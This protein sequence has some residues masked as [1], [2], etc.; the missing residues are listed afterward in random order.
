MHSIFETKHLII[1]ALCAIFITA[2]TLATRKWSQEKLCKA[3]FYIG[4]VAEF[5]KVFNYIL[6]N[7]AELGGI[8]PKTDLPFHLCSMQMPMVAI[9][10]L[11][12]SEKLK[13]MI[14]SFMMPGCLVGA[15]AALLLATDSSLNGSV[16]ITLEYFGYHSVLVIFGL[17]LLM[18]KLEM[19]VRSYVNCLKCLL[20][21]FFFSIY[22]N[23][24]LYDGVSDINFMYV[25]SPP[26][27]GLPYLTEEHGW[28]VYIVHY[29]ALVLFGVT[30][31]YCKPLIAAL[32]NKLSEPKSAV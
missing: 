1:L 32:R 10:T 26:M 20:I 31:C 18:G 8:L 13:D 6:A 2:G 25:A 15:A 27:E 29:A 28:L 12:K 7:E 23:S 21:V 3:L 4:I 19:S 14:L 9:V 24:I 11:C 5:I 16:A 17:Q 30:V 22:I